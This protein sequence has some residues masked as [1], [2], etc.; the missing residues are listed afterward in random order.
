MNSTSLGRLVYFLLAGVFLA[1]ALFLVRA[2]EA[3]PADVLP[4]ANPKDAA[5]TYRERIR[6]TRKLLTEDRFGYGSL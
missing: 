5:K 3:Q 6:T 4:F 2:R 1:T